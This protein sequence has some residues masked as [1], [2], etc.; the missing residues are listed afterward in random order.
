MN[1]PFVTLTWLQG[2]VAIAL[3]AGVCLYVLRDLFRIWRLK[4]GVDRVRE[5][6]IRNPDYG[7]PSDPAHQGD[8]AAGDRTWP[9]GAI[10]LEPL[11]SKLRSEGG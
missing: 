6:S 2:I 1:Q 10:Y 4:R 11:L 9:Q 7:K 3:V 5:R 8:A